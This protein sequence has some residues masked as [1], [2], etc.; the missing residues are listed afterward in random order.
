LKKKLIGQN[1]EMKWGQ[2]GAD[3]QDI[4]TGI[5][6]RRLNYLGHGMEDTHILNTETEGR[7]RVG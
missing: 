4:V 5:K 1:V 6:F 2:E 7:H 3:S